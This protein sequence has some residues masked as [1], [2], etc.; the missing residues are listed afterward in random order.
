[1]VTTTICDRTVNLSLIRS[2]DWLSDEEINA[3][4]QLLKRQF[5]VLGG[6]QDVLLGNFDILYKCKEAWFVQV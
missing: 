5:P 4:L 2:G 3:G 1:M 6:F